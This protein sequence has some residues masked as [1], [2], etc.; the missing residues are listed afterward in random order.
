MNKIYLSNPRGFCAGVKYAIS[1]VENVHSIYQ[2][3]QIYVRKEIV[4]NRRVVNDM[5]KKGIKFINE[6]DEAP[7]SS[8]VIFSA[9]GVSPE[10]VQT[11]KDKNMRIGDATCPLVTR[12]HRKA[13]KLKETHQIIYIGHEGHDE[14]I[15]TMG[16]AEMFLVES[17][18]DVLSLKGKVNPNKPLTYLMQTTLSVSDTKKVIDKIAEV[19][20]SVEHPDKDDICYATTERQEAVESMMDSIDA[21][22]V[23]GAPNSSNSMRLVQLAQK[24]KEKSFRVSSADE[25]KKEDLDRLDIETMGI[26]AGAS[27][28]QVLIDEIIAKI[29]SFYPDV[30]VENFP[31][32]REDSMNF[33]LPKELLK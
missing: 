1:F 33:K 9:H 14:A 6:L 11:A 19:F 24:K 28:P 29:L 30:I 13:K 10:V 16:E 4:H 7:E 23:I 2:N 25:I 15:G 27:S 31:D 18:E 22:L 12:V 26:T 3:E 32:S 21:M 17:E 8:I 5:E 20:P